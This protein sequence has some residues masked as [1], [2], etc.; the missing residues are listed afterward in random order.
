M[1]RNTPESRQRARSV[2]CGLC[3]TRKPDGCDETY[4]PNCVAYTAW[5]KAEMPDG[6]ARGHLL[7][8]EEAEIARNIERYRARAAAG[9][10]IFGDDGKESAA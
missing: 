3:R 1:T 2:T 7:P 10:P 9:L 8:W 4:C 6:R 5:R